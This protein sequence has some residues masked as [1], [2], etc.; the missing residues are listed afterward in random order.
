MVVTPSATP[1]T[2]PA[3]TVA[4]A[5]LD[6]VHVTV[7]VTSCVLLSPSVPVAVKFAVLPGA[8]RPLGG[9][10]ESAMIACCDGKKFEFPQFVERA[11]T[12]TAQLTANRADLLTNLIR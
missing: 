4:I 8:T 11:S 10:M 7:E 12:S 5:G 1:F 6:D 9:E 3:L 2:L